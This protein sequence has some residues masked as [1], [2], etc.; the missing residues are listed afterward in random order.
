MSERGSPTV[1]RRRLGYELRLLREAAGKKGE[2]VA[3]ALGWSDSKISRIET[4]RISVHHGDVADLLDLYEVTDPATRDALITLARQTRKQGWWHPYSDIL[5]RHYATY[6]GLETAAATLRVFEPLTV[7]GL[8]QTETYARAVI[9]T[10]TQEIS[11]EEVERLIEVRLRRQDVVFKSDDPL[12]LLVVLDEAALHRQI[13]GP[14]VMHEQITRLIEVG[15]H[16]RIRLQVLSFDQGSHVGMA[17]SFGIFE[18]PD[19]SDPEIGFVE[20]VAGSLFL[21]RRAEVQAARRAF[22]DLSAHALSP[23]DSATLLTQVSATSQQ[24][25]QEKRTRSRRCGDAPA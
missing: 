6:I 15:A 25:T 11:D 10:N 1:R 13:A 2:D 22:D 8:L 3:A 21:E 12:R 23:Q 7:P 20:T 19:P 14:A 4:G 24:R 18:F 17:G 9:R 16:P 5:Q